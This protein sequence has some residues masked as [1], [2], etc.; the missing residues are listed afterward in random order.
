MRFFGSGSSTW[1]RTNGS[2]WKSCPCPAGHSVNRWRDWRPDWRG[3]NA[4]WWLTCAIRL[5]RGTGSTEEEEIETYHDRV[6][7]AVTAHLPADVLAEHHRRLA[8]VL[9]ASGEDDPDVLGDHLQRA[10]ERQRAGACFA[11]A[12]KEAADA[13]A[14]DRAATLYR[15]SLE[16]GAM[17][18]D[19][20]RGLRIRLAEALGNAGRGPEAAREYLDAAKDAGPEQALDLR[21]QAA[22]RLLTC[23]HYR[24]GLDALRPVLDSAG[25]MLPGSPVRAF[26]PLLLARLRLR[27]RGLNFALRPSEEIASEDLRYIDI[28]W[29]VGVGLFP[30]DLVSAWLFLTRALLRA[31]TVGDS[32]RIARVGAGGIVSGQ[33]RRPA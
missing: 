12:A 16:L 24:E 5:L 17:P 27:L 31:L 30:V 18:S 19:E 22:L 11:R 28:C 1:G 26:W 33:P 21:R 3:T 25:L 6:R 20:A 15:R 10:G 8:R 4:P 13:L 29:A 9:E 23:G 14:F 32:L 2:C 7:E